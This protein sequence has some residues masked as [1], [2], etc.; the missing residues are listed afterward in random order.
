[1]SDSDSTQKQ[2]PV[3]HPAIREILRHFR[4]KHLRPDLQAVS[5]AFCDL[6]HEMADRFPAGGAELTVCLRK[7]LEAKDAAVRVALPPTDE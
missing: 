4:Y 3:H 2:P 7:L 1:M 5:R 6:A